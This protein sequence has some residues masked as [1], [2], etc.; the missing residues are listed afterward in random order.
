[1]PGIGDQILAEPSS[2]IQSL[3]EGFR[4]HR[5]GKTQGRLSRCGFHPHSQPFMLGK[6]VVE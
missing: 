1:M 5:S 6:I 2:R 3:G 4:S